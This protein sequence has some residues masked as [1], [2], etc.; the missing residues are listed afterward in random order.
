MGNLNRDEIL[1]RLQRGELIKGARRLS[2]GKFDVEA[3]SYDLS[4]G[5]AVRKERDSG[6]EK[7]NVTTVS[8][9]PGSP[10]SEQPTVTVQPGQMIFVVTSESVLCP[11]DLCATVYS[12]NSLAAEGILLLNAGHVDPG[13]EGPIVIRLI[14][15]RM[16]PWTLTLGTPI[17][18][19][20]FQ[21]IDVAAGDVLVKHPAI[22]PEETLIRVRR[23]ADAALSNALLDIFSIEMRQRLDEHYIVAESR[24]RE[25]LSKTYLRREE[26]LGALLKASWKASWKWILAL[27]TVGTVAGVV[28]AVL[29]YFDVKGQ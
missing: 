1:R 4:A 18:T 16:T 5:T 2:D 7:G 12:R 23:T 9:M 6:G 29:S 20:V 17:F 3:D 10:L 8:H 24:L 19:I 27:A 11:T 14:N 28:L 13:F 15:L 22:T 25:E 26:L 21:T